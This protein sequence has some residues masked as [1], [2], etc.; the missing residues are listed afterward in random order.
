MFWG[1]P[2]SICLISSS[3]V[4]IHFLNSTALSH[5]WYQLSKVRFSGRQYWARIWSKGCLLGISSSEGRRNRVEQCE[6]LSCGGGAAKPQAS[7]EWSVL[8]KGE[9]CQV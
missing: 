7:L 9:F 5:F 1:K 3:A 8:F 6:K 4:R 2:G